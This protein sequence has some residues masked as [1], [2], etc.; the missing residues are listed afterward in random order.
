MPDYIVPPLTTEPDDLAAE[1]FAYLEDAIPG[2][3]PSP[4]NLEAWLVESLSQLAGELMDVASAVPPEIFAYFGSSVLG[5]PPQ[6]ATPATATTHWTMADDLGYTVL[7]GTLIGIPAAGDELLGFATQEDFTV[8]VGQTTAAGIVVVAEDAGADGNGLTGAPELVDAFDFVVDISLDAPTAGGTDGETTD[9]YLTRL[10]GLLTLLS[11]RPILPGDF[12]VIAK[13]NPAVERATAIDLFQAGLDLNPDPKAGPT[14][15]IPA[16]SATPV[17]RCVTV[18]VVGA[19]GQPVGDAVRQDVANELDALREVNFLVYVIDPTYT[20]VAVTFSATVY[21][22]YD[23]QGVIDQAEADVAAYLSPANFGVPPF[24]DQPAWIND[25][26]V[27]YL[28]VAEIV[29]RTEGLWY[30]VDLKLN[31][32]T[33]D[34]TLTGPAPLPN[35][36]PPPVGTLVVT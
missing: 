35:A 31:G 27:R 12:A 25:T 9:E 8:P 21:A 34:V 30:I 20:N 14:T 13:Q 22:G 4:P 19:D 32:G 16:T 24:G 15:P 28:E 29:N 18:A 26:K 33:A 2:W 7:A 23:A 10:R 6:L 17:E 36:V 11:P 3:L 1:A 5:L